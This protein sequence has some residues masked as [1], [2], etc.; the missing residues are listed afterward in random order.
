[1][2]FHLPWYWMPTTAC[3]QCKKQEAQRGKNAI[4]HT[5]DHD[6]GSTDSQLHEWC[7]LVN[8]AFYLLAAWLE[9]DTLVDLLR[10]VLQHRMY[11]DARSD[12]AE[13]DMPLLQFYAENYS[14]S[15][16][17]RFTVNPPNHVICLL[18]W[19]LV[20]ALLTKVGHTRYNR[21]RRSHRRL[22]ST[23]LNVVVGDDSV[24]MEGKDTKTKIQSILQKCDQEESEAATK[25]TKRSI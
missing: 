25:E 2:R 1:M 9:C 24:S 12:F 13:D 16:P 22:T 8:G 20:A 7:Q 23:R 17:N 21:F 10:H 18:N 6:G 19:E 4:N 11:Q 15:H 14:D 5:L 3:W